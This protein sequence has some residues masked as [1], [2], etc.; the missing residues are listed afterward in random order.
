MI[1]FVIFHLAKLWCLFTIVPY[2]LNYQ[3]L[4]KFKVLI[5]V[6]KDSNLSKKRSIRR[7]LR[8][9]SS[10]AAGSTS[11]WGSWLPGTSPALQHPGARFNRNNLSLK[12]EPRG[13]LYNFI[14]C[15]TTNFLNFFQWRES[16]A[17]LKLKQS[18]FYWIGSHVRCCPRRLFPRSHCKKCLEEVGPRCARRRESSQ[19][20][21]QHD[22]S[23]G[24]HDLKVESCEG[25][26][27][28]DCIRLHILSF[29]CDSGECYDTPLIYEIIMAVV[30]LQQYNDWWIRWISKWMENTVGFRKCV[31]WNFGQMQFSEKFQHRSKWRA[32]RRCENFISIWIWQLD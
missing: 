26:W 15:V 13:F 6:I 14:T 2:K 18:V 22:Q 4:I 28:W 9:R 30:M 10:R 12:F 16:Q 25:R 19:K 7:A 21:D 20:E 8:S 3:S 27:W 31:Y 1:T 17:I 23:R 11:L 29:K 5:E 32:T 24:L